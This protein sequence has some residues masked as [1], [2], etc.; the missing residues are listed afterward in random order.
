M[1]ECILNTDMA[2]HFGD[3]GK[4][5]GRS[6]AEDFDP[7]GN[8]KDKD[9]V[10]Q[11]S[12]HLADISNTLKKWHLCKTW[13]DLLFQEFFTQGDHEKQLGHTV[14]MLND[15]CTTNLAKGQQGFIDFVIKPAYTAL[16]NVIPKVDRNLLQMEENKES[17]K[18]LIPEYEERMKR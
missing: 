7:A 15:R 4:F 14:G 10:I 8:T 5:K 18:E 17:W 11:M 13:I 3:V 16:V 1:I 2:K 6:Q 9:L 12:F